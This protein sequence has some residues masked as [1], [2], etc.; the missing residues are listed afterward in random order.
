V[1]LLFI[2]EYSGDVSD[3]EHVRQLLDSLDQDEN[4][5]IVNVRYVLHH[6]QM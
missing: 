5:V 3:D 6:T 4:K 2:P 1:R